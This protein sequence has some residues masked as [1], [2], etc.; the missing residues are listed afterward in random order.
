[1]LRGIFINANAHKPICSMYYRGLAAFEGFKLSQKVDF[2]YIDASDDSEIPDFINQ[3]DLIVFNYHPTTMAD[4]S[5]HIL[6][7]ITPFKIGLI[8]DMT[9]DP[10]SFQSHWPSGFNAVIYPDPLL[11]N[12]DNLLWQFD[13]IVPRTKF[14]YKP[15]NFQ[16]PIISTFGIPDDRKSIEN[17]IYAINEEFTT[18]TFRINFSPGSHI[19]SAGLSEI[20]RRSQLATDIAHSGIKVEYSEKFMSFD[21][22]MM[23]LNESD[24]NIFFYDKSRDETHLKNL[25]ST[26]DDAIAAK[27][28]IAVSDNECV[29]HFTQY[30]TPY[31]DSSLVDIMYYGL[32]NIKVVYNKWS[33]KNWAAKFDTYIEGS[34]NAIIH[35]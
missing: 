23:W 15:V 2:E 25:P 32:D 20:R 21:D 16:N 13:R 35:R 10:F 19:P 26:L 30:Q 1:M 28:P 3:Y 12:S 29:K 9:K 22:L 14:S 7:Q 24:L 31:P 17:I 34:Y 5:D 11:N 4:I 27:R 18:A 6:R 33:P 8:W